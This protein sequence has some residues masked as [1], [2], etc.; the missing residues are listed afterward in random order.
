MNKLFFSI[1]TSILLLLFIISI[2]NTAQAA[3][4]TS[5]AIY[6]VRHA[7]KNTL[8]PPGLTACGQQRAEDLIEVFQS[9]DIE[10][11]YSTDFLRSTRTVQPIAQQRNLTINLY[12]APTLA[13]FAQKL[14]REKKNALVVGHLNTTPMLAGFLSGNSYD[15]IKGADYNRIYQVVIV[16]GTPYASILQPP[17]KCVEPEVGQ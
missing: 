9:I 11:I 4:N 13:D 1:K 15:M 16:A 5:F 17:L 8:S 14:L 10:K 7:E 2:G 6:L 12:G 3:Q